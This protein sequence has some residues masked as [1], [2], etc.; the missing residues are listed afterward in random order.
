MFQ[1]CTLVSAYFL[2]CRNP[3]PNSLTT[4]YSI[5]SFV[6]NDRV[7]EFSTMFNVAAQ[8]AF[9]LGAPK[10]KNPVLESYGA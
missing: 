8:T 10:V 3:N 4:K 2:T 6:L 7:R 9:G 5:Y 1:R